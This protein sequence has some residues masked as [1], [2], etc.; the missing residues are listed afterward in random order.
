MWIL[1][2]TNI[3]LAEKLTIIL[4]YIYEIWPCDLIVK[5]GKSFKFGNDTIIINYNNN[6]YN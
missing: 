6:N 1:S 5:I 4:I 3:K 2:S